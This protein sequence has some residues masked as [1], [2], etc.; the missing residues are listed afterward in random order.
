MEANSIAREKFGQNNSG[1]YMPHISLFY[2]DRPME[3]K[4]E[5][6]EHIISEFDNVVG[7]TVQFSEIE[8]WS[9]QGYVHE[10][11]KVGSVSLP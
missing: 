8:V 7:H 1:D 10:W 5:I 4:E 2:G 11:Y 9:T 3:F 6:K